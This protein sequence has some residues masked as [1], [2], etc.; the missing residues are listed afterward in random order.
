MGDLQIK[1]PRL[2]HLLL[3]KR[4]RA[5]SDAHNTL[6]IVVEDRVAGVAA[7]AGGVARQPVADVVTLIG[8]AH[9]VVAVIPFAE[10]G[11]A[12]ARIR[13]LE[14]ARNIQ[15]LS[16]NGGP[17]FAVGLILV[18]RGRLRN[19]Q[20]PPRGTAKRRGRV[21]AREDHPL[22]REPFDVGRAE[23]VAGRL[24]VAGIMRC[25]VPTQL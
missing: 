12:V 9:V 8:G 4:T 5:I 23:I 21:A 25:D 11:G 19:L 24:G 22:G 16:V 18:P 1:R 3:H 10:V 7:A 6:G 17:A 15:L 14:H 20:T 13:G 2:A